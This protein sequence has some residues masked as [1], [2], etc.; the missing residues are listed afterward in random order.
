MLIKYFSGGTQEQAFGHESHRGSN[1]GNTWV[2]FAEKDILYNKISVD[3][4]K[5]GQAQKQIGQLNW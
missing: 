4:K 5:E 1:Y 2:L 3:V